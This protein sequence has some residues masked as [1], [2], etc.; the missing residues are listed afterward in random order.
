MMFALTCAHQS[1]FLARTDTLIVSTEWAVAELPRNPSVMNKEIAQRDI[2]DLVR[3]QRVQESHLGAAHISPY[4]H[5]GNLAP[6]PSRLLCSCPTRPA[7][8]AK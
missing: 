2:V 4:N 6:P 5:E 3:D 8:L 1:A 7:K